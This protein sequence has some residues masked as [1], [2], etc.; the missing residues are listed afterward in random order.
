MSNFIP[1][2]RKLSISPWCYYLILSRAIFSCRF[3]CECDSGYSQSTNK[4]TCIDNN[5]CL[6]NNGGCEQICRNTLGGY[7][8]GCKPGY[9]AI[10]Q[11]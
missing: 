7:K 8:C 6:Q 4:T 1:K 9:Q 3:V 5:E 10:P 11:K 2:Q